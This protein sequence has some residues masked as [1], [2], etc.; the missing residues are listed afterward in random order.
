[1]LIYFFI[2]LLSTKVILLK[3]LRLNIYLYMI[4]KKQK[5]RLHTNVKS[6]FRNILGTMLITLKSRYR[7]ALPNSFAYKKRAHLIHIHRGLF[8]FTHRLHN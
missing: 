1:M 7:I 4:Y 5:K 8:G 2:F 6:L 3:D